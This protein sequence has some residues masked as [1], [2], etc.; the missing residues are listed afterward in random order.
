MADQFGGVDKG[1][2]VEG[3]VC[4]DHCTA[5]DG[6]GWKDFNQLLLETM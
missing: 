4:L 5:S 3:D 2:V 1:E 6:N